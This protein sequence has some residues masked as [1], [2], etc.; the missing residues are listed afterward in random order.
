LL[1]LERYVDTATYDDP[2]RHPEGVA[3]VW[4]AGEG[5]WCDGRHTGARPGGVVRA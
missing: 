4:V 1:D 3:G 2:K 5:V